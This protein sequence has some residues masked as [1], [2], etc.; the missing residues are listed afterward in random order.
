VKYI[1]VVR[2][3]RDALISWYHGASAFPSEFLARM[4]RNGMT[5]DQTGT[6]LPRVCKTLREEFHRWLTQSVC[7]GDQ[8]GPPGEMGY[9]AEFLNIQVSDARMSKYVDAAGF[10]A[11]KKD[12]ENLF[13]VL[14][15]KLKGGAGSFLRNGVN[16]QWTG[17]FD[18]ADPDLYEHKLDTPLGAIRLS[19]L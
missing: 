10:D 13:P 3:G 5:D 15:E 12:R 17:Q 1:H 6:P 19:A 14:G 2:D 11:M 4:D 9:V 18:H 8:D 16:Q 7:P